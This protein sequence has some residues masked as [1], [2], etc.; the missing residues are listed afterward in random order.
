MAKSLYSSQKKGRQ[1]RVCVFVCFKG[2]IELP[3]PDESN[4]YN[5]KPGILERLYLYRVLLCNMQAMQH[6]LYQ[7]KG[8]LR[9]ETTNGIPLCRRKLL[10]SHNGVEI[11]STE[12]ATYCTRTIYNQRF[13]CHQ[14]TF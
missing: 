14:T 2:R 7:L 10:M 3:L 11:F 8:A 9:T 5:W 4:P 13:A 1:L 6:N 12:E